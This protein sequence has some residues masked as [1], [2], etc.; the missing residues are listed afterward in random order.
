VP[1]NIERC[2]IEVR[3]RITGSALIQLGIDYWKDTTVEWKGYNVNNTEA[4][5][6]DWYFN[7]NEWATLNFAKPD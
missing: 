7:S 3:C 6:S 1:Q 2:W 5:V 4:G